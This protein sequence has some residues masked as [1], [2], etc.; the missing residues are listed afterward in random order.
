MH[1]VKESQGRSGNVPLW[2]GWIV[3]FGLEPI[4]GG[5]NETTAVN[6]IQVIGAGPFVDKFTSTEIALS[7]AS[8]C[9][10]C[11]SEQVGDRR[12]TKVHGTG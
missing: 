12:K 7:L 1:N 8:K 9:R 3:S 10:K 11:L 4:N 5:A 2:I 6:H